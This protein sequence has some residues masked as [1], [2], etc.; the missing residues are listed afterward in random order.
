MSKRS[1]RLQR[2]IREGDRGLKALFD[3]RVNMAPMVSDEELA[4]QNDKFPGDEFDW[5]RWSAKSVSG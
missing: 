3:I 1:K 2:R 5:A 4:A